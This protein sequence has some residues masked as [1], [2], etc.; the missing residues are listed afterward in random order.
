[1]ARATA[2]LLLLLAALLPLARSPPGA[3]RACR[4]APRGSPPRHWLGCQADPGP[5]RD[6]DDEERLLL[7]RPLD[8][9]RASARALAFLPGLSA[10]LARAIVEDRARRGPFRDVD[11]ILRVRG[12][13]PVRLARARPWLEVRATW[14]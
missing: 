4:P 13:G 9:N 7:R 8:V 11:E 2:R 6:L 10:R 3:A 1:M 12:I 5:G 14:R